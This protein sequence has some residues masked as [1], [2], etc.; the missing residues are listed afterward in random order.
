MER[1]VAIRGFAFP[2]NKEIGLTLWGEIGKDKAFNYEVGIFGGDGQNRPQVDNRVDV[3]GRVFVRP[4][5][6]VI[7]DLE[8]LQIGLS[9]KHGDRDP[10]Y[11]GYDYPAIASGHGFVLWAPTYRDKAGRIIHIIPSGAQNEIGGEVR[12]PFKRFEA[13]AELYYVAN[14][15]REG[16]EG[17]QL[18]NTERLGRVKGVAW[19]TQLS[20]WPLGDA[21]VNGDPG[22]MR[23]PHIDFAKKPDLKKG[24]E[25]YGIIAGVNGDYDGA[26]RGGGYDEKTPGAPGVAKNITI[27]QYGLG[28]TYWYTKFVR[29]TLNY[30]LYH[31]P[32]STTSENMA[33]VPGNLVK[34][35]AD[36]EA[37][38][39]HEIGTRL[40]LWF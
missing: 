40:G 29:A 5:K 23:P 31:T 14:R 24:L 13:R 6:G 38:V 21:F 8:K 4:L 16:V 12:V 36:K 11:V 37:H 1:S 25:V 2:S 17:Y 19:Y 10:D 9:A 39:L 34:P 26:S 3:L 20:A 27:M 32:L 28:A 35:S 15:T 18:T 7:E 30:N 22:M 33:L